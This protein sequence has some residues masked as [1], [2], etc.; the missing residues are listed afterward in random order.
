MTT[1]TR[2]DPA[3]RPQTAA[4]GVVF[5]PYHPVRD[6]SP[7]SVH[8]RRSRHPDHDRDRLAL[9]AWM[10]LAMYPRQTVYNFVAGGRP[11]G[12]AERSRFGVRNLW[13]NELNAESMLPQAAD[14]KSIAPVAEPKP[15]PNLP[16]SPKPGSHLARK[17]T[18]G[19]TD[20]DLR[21]S[22][23]WWGTFAVR[24]VGS[25]PAEYRHRPCLRLALPGRSGTTFRV[26]QTA[27]PP[28]QRQS[29]AAC[30]SRRGLRS[31]SGLRLPRALP[32][33]VFWPGLI[34]HSALFALLWWLALFAP[35]A[36]RRTLRRRRGSAR[37]A[38][39]TSA[40][41]RPAHL[42]RVRPRPLPIGPSLQT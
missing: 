22:A 32:L 1:N 14:F 38:A 30:C 17:Q 7:A 3:L 16:S 15:D 25:H 31:K 24:R 36:F 20:L 12:A 13:F 10:P 39:T 35:G 4:P 42:S 40:A 5:C 8:C 9:A 34:P 29:R 11:W 19:R 2:N 33:W 41:I 23:P 6:A 28:R 21:D 37:R 26:S 27:T 18:A